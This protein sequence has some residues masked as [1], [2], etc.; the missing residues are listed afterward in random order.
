M[1][2]QASALY[3]GTVMHRRLR[4]RAHRLKYRMASLLL[5]LDEID[6]LARRLRLFARNRFGLFAFHDADHLDGTG[7]PLRPQVEARLRAAGIAP[8]GGA[9]RVLA[10]PRMLGFVFNPLSVWFCHGADGRLIATI[11]E[12]NNTFGERHCYVIGAEPGRGGLLDQACD[13]AFHVSPFMPMELGYRFRVAPP[14]A[15]VSIGITVSDAAGPLLSAV[16]SAGARR[17][18]DGALARVF[19]THPF[20]TLKVVAGILWEALRLWL[21]R[22][23]IHDHRPQGAER[24]SGPTISRTP[25]GRAAGNPA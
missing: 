10:M 20:A 2:G 1:S 4:P 12:V 14:G 21:K 18:T 16:H 5:D 11:Y 22:V 19:M 8:E 23:P 13:K 6:G 25:P 17:L 24:L 9:I 15:R 3:I 7:A